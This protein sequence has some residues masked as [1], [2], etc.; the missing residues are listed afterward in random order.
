MKNI[1]AK[2]LVEELPHGS[3][4]DCDWEITATSKSIRFK[5]SFHNMNQHGYYVGYQDFTVRLPLDSEDWVGDFILTLNGRRSKCA[6]SLR[7]Y[8][9]DTIAYSLGEAEKKFNVFFAIH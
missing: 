2:W 7:E 4:I 8:L 5:N 9:T 6:D 3:G 1:I